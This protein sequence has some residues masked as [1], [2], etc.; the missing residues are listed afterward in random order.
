MFRSVAFCLGLWRKYG[1]Y[2]VGMN[3]RSGPSS[4]IRC[5]CGLW[6]SLKRSSLTGQRDRISCKVFEAAILFRWT[7]P[8]FLPNQYGSSFVALVWRCLRI[9]QFREIQGHSDHGDC[10]FV[11]VS[12]LLHAC[13][14]SCIRPVSKNGSAPGSGESVF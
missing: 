6:A 2:F 12:A 14:P 13:L 5:L 9:K 3:K 10:I 8:S 7:C 1:Q 4:K 11:A